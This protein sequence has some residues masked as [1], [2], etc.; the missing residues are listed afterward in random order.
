MLEVMKFNVKVKVNAKLESVTAEADGSL[1]V[2][3]HAPPHEGL[4]NK[5]V[6]ELLAAYFKRPKKAL[7]LLHGEKSKSKIFELDE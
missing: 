2:K 7:R 4:A 5:R 1:T 6:L 3:V